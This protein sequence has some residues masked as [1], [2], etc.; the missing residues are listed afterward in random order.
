[1]KSVTK[2]TKDFKK[3]K[4]AFTPLQHLQESESN[5]SDDEYEDRASHFQIAG[6]RFQ[7]TQLNQEFK[8]RIAKLFNQAQEVNI[9]LNLKEIILLDSQSTII[10][11]CNTALVANKFKSSNIMRLKSNGGTMLVT[12][13]GEMAGYHKKIGLARE[14]LQILLL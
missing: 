4:K 3:M 6:S 10:F 12:H 14:L 7:V 2:F 9:K 11:F 5:L 8:P 13:K 1:M